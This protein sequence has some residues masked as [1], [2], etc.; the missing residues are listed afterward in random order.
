[1]FLLY[2]VSDG[3]LAGIYVAVGASPNL[4]GGNADAAAATAFVSPGL[5][6]V[7]NRKAVQELAHCE[8]HLLELN[9]RKKDMEN[10]PRPG[11]T[12]VADDASDWSLKSLKTMKTLK[13]MG[14]NS[15]CCPGS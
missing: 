10:C 9:S 12:E 11:S 14:Y 3:G 4:P 2:H 6:V 8:A 1:M 7:M 5:M 13:E 15:I